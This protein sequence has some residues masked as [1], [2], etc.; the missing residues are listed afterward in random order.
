[1]SK[2]D[3]GHIVSDS[4]DSAQLYVK[5]KLEHA[6]LHLVE[7]ITL[8]STYVISRLV[9]SVLL[10]L[11]FVFGSVALGLYLAT[12]MPAYFAFLIIAGIYLVAIPIMFIL[13]NTLIRKVMFRTVFREIV[14]KRKS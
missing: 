5:F 9:V 10:V 12:L 2:Q 14:L 1:M 13:R 3:L 8:L 4:K 7:K 11:S 6:K